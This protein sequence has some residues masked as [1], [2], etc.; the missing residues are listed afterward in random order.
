MSEHPMDRATE[1]QRSIIT[2][3]CE[4]D[5]TVKEIAARLSIDASTVKSH[6][7]TII[8][9]FRARTMFRVCAMYGEWKE[10]QAAAEIVR[11]IR[12]KG[13]MRADQI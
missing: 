8:A 5:L 1:R 12:S 3:T 10:T 6:R 2:M 11:L 9:R 13:A 4:E 7:T